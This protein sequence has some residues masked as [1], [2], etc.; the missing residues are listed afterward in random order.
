MK[1]K[2]SKMTV[3]AIIC[4]MII[5][6]WAGLSLAEEITYEAVFSANDISFG[7]RDGFDTV[8]MKGCP[9]T[10]ARPGKPELPYKTIQFALPKGKTVSSIAILSD[11][12]T[13]LPGKRLIFPSKDNKAGEVFDAVPPDPVIYRSDA[14]YPAERVVDGGEAVFAGVRIATVRVYPIE[15]M[16]LSKKLVLH[17]KIVFGLKLDDIVSSKAYAAPPVLN[18]A[19]FGTLKK[20]V[21]NPDAVVPQTAPKATGERAGYL[22]ITSQAIKEATE[23]GMNNVVD[24]GFSKLCKEKR[25]R[26][27]I[28][29]ESVENIGTTMPG[30]DLAEKIRNY[31]IKRNNDYGVP[32]VLLGG[33]TDNADG[34]M[35]VPTRMLNLVGNSGAV[36]SV[37]CDMYYSCLDGDWDADGDS[38]FGQVTDGVDLIPEVYVGRAPVRTA[39]DAALFSDKIMSYKTNAL[40]YANTAL[41]LGADDFHPRSCGA[42]TSHNSIVANYLEPYNFNYYMIHPQKYEDRKDKTYELINEGYNFIDIVDHASYSTLLIGDYGLGW[43]EFMYPDPTV[44]RAF[45]YS[46]NKPSICIATGCESA[47]IDRTGGTIAEV[48]IL[49][50]TGGGPAYIGNSAAGV[51]WHATFQE[52]YNSIFGKSLSNI[53]V[54]LTVAKI[55]AMLGFDYEPGDSYETNNIV[56][57]GIMQIVLLGDPEMEAYFDKGV[58]LMGHPR[59]IDRPPGGNYDLRLDPGETA[60]ITM[61]LKARNFDAINV[62][63]AISTSDPDIS[64]VNGTSTFGVIN[65]GETVDNLSNPFKITLSR[66]ISKRRNIEFDIETNAVGYK[67]IASYKVDAGYWPVFMNSRDIS[68]TSISDIDGD[69]SL[70]IVMGAGGMIYCLDIYGRQKWPLP[71]IADGRF[72]SAPALVDL[73]RDGR[74][75]IVMSS[76]NGCLYCINPNGTFRWAYQLGAIV[77]PSPSAADIDGDSYPEIL[78]GCDNYYLYCIDKNGAEKWRFGTGRWIQSSAAIADIDNDGSLE[79]LI[80]SRDG[81]LYCVSKTGQKKWEYATG[82]QILSSPSISDIDRDGRLEVMVGSDDKKI[83]AIRP[84]GTL[85]WS[86]DGGDLVRSCPALADM[87]G[88][89]TIEIVFACGNKVYCLS[90]NGSR[91]WQ[92]EAEGPVY[93]SP[94]LA[95]LDSDGQLETLIGAADDKM[96]CIAA[97]GNLKWSYRMGGGVSC[98]AAISELDGYGGP[99]ALFGSGDGK[100]YCVNKDGLDFVPTSPV[101]RVND[102]PWPMFQADIRH[103]GRYGSILP[104][105]TISINGGNYYANSAN[106]T[107]NWTAV[108]GA[109]GSAIAGARVANSPPADWAAVNRVYYPN[110]FQWTL[111]SGDGVKTVYMRVEDVAGNMSAVVTDSI[112]LDTIAPYPDISINSGA[113]HTNSRNV[114]LTLSAT[115]TGSGMGQGSKMK[116]SNTNPVDWSTVPE[117]DYPG[118]HTRQ[119]GLSSG[120]GVKTVYAKFKDAAGNWSVADLGTIIFDDVQ[121]TGS[122]SFS[123]RPQ[124]IN[125]LNVALDLSASDTGSGVSQMKVYNFGEEGSAPWEPYA[126]TKN[127]TLTGPDGR[128]TVYAKFKDRAG[129][130]SIAY[131]AT[132]ILDRVPPVI[133]SMTVNIPGDY[134]TNPNRIDVSWTAATDTASGIDHY[135]YKVIADMGFPEVLRWASSGG[136]A[137]YASITRFDRP[138]VS[139]YFYTI[140]VR[141]IDRAGNGGGENPGQASEPKQFI[142]MNKISGRITYGGGA[143]VPGVSILV[144]GKPIVA[145]DSNGYYTVN[146]LTAGNYTLVPSKEWHSFNPLLKQIVISGADVT[147]NFT[148]T[149]VIAPTNLNAVNAFANSV[150]LNWTDNSNNEDSFLVYRGPFPAKGQ[151]LLATLPANTTTY[152]DNT[153]APQTLYYYYVKANLGGLVSD[154]TNYLAVDMHN[155]PAAPFNLTA[156][157]NAGVYLQWQWTDSTGSHCNGYIIGRSSDNG[158]SWAPIGTTITKYYRDATAASGVSYKYRIRAYKDAGGIRYSSPYSNE[159]AITR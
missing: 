42:T 40:T 10:T 90:G 36:E 43:V 83:Y 131:Y 65:S 149:T 146:Y 136:T 15:Y 105:G 150:A 63:A 44:I 5:L 60:D 56:R 78:V 134:I 20:M 154:R 79:I 85:Y 118:L 130:E 33:D 18:A 41:L 30:R 3:T 19:M 81:K 32:W 158:S 28:I 99:K 37:A 159:V 64:I 157:I 138:L 148:A 152:T 70:E 86:Y 17:N 53:G 91:L 107:I 143:P 82:G 84:N 23:R 57:K 133:D 94:A 145:T 109:S 142:P 141:A 132:T 72:A 123:G 8:S 77:W 120:N 108:M 46:N 6:I 9:A 124:Y 59:I 115:D 38:N 101:I 97:N 102:N 144:P 25:D 50:P 100:I 24:E 147:Q 119:W 27:N 49:S 92:H 137:T 98:S 122:I 69:G 139:G 13:T 45:N 129:N 55:A 66:N 76:T 68:S 22:I 62:S 140:Y 151:P 12:K 96:Y 111:A 112:V 104:T 114:T 11:E 47:K 87:D 156:S 80:G 135:E 113:Q 71:Y 14:G 93:F 88:D 16:P 67:G 75:E 4:L 29:M 48:W 58:G 54:A 125:T 61:S 95:D 103:S 126:A 74:R 121:P 128:K 51:G 155:T 127:W 26:V 35:L 73:D 7:L 52:F 31:I 34:S 39:E 2:T 117:E 21:A 106:S 89:G 1:T 116:I 153:I 110:P